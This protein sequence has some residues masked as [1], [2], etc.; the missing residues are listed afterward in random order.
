MLF[1]CMVAALAVGGAEALVVG[2]PSTMSNARTTSVTMGVPASVKIAGI[3]VPTAGAALLAGTRA[4]QAKKDAAAA[5][6]GRAALAGMT[7][8]SGLSELSLEPAN[9]ECVVIGDWKEYT[10]ANGKKWCLIHFYKRLNYGQTLRTLPEP[11]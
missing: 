2:T 1:R 8:L 5:A 10:K 9:Q 6:Q 11:C 4:I 3:I 7:S